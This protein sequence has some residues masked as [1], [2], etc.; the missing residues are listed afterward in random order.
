M[1][2]GNRNVSHQESRDR[3]IA[4]LAARQHGVVSGAQ[5]RHL[6]MDRWAIHRRVVSGRW[7]EVRPR[8]YCLAGAP[9]TRQRQ[10]FEAILWAGEGAVLSHFTAAELWNLD[11][12]KR[13]AEVDVLREKTQKRTR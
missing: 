3:A 1:R 4:E 2:G 10:L 5:A 11:G 12:I 13:S 7:S 8:V 9:L 6:E